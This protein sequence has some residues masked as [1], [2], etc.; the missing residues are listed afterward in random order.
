MSKVLLIGFP[1]KEQKKVASFFQSVEVNTVT[2]PS[3]DSALEKIS[4]DPPT[5][6]VADRPTRPEEIFSLREV[7]KQAAPATP[8]LVVLPDAR[9]D[10]ALQ[11]MRA[12]A[13]DCLSRP[14]ERTQVLA[15]AKRAAARSG[16]TLFVPKVRPRP[17]RA[18]LIASAFLSF[19]LTATLIGLLSRATPAPELDLGSA[20]LSG[21]QWNGRQLWA[22][23]WFDSTVTLYEV[24][25]SVLGRSTRLIT[26]EVVKMQ[27]TQ[28]ILICE[29]KTDFVTVGFDLVFRRHR[30]TPGLPTALVEKAPGSNPTGLAWDGKSLWSCDGGTGLLYRHGADL[31]VVESI[32]SLVSEPSGLTA[33]HGRVWVTG[34]TPL[35]VAY[36]ERRGKG[37]VW[38]GPWPAADLLPEGVSPTG[39]AIGHKRLWAVAG[40]DPRMMSISLRRFQSIPDAWKP[41][42]PGTS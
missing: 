13:Y 34:G 16:R 2:L 29:T 5:L 28:P 23:N 4:S 8:F 39:I 36:L 3:I 11:A 42:H 31:K 9:V 15:A 38:S 1:A 27:D 19:L 6:I 17:R 20:T 41:H 30:R 26:R 32:R 35:K 22:G 25:R 24:G 14:L 37:Y 21:L 40:G 12:G 10:L 33:E 18:G 7:L